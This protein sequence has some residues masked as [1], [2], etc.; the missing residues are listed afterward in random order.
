MTQTDSLKDPIYKQIKDSIFPVIAILLSIHFL[1]NFTQNSGLKYFYL[2]EVAYTIFACL[3]YDL[4]KAMIALMGL[5]FIEGQ[6]RIIWEYNPLMR[7]MFDLVCGLAVAKSLITY[8][9]LFS[10]KIPAFFLFCINLHFFWYVVQIFNVYNAGILPVI[11]ASKIYIFPFILFFV[12]LQNPIYLESREFKQIQ[13]LVIFLTLM[14]V[15]LTVYQMNGKEPVLLSISSYYHTASKMGIFTEKN[16]R[17]FGTSFL[18]GGMSMYLHVTVPLLLI[19]T[20]Q[21]FIKK[22]VTF[23]VILASWFA[24]FISQVRALAFKHVLTVLLCWIVLFLASRKSLFKTF[25]HNILKILLILPIFFLPATHKMLQELDLDTAIDRFTV[26]AEEGGSLEK[27]RVNLDQAIR[28]MSSKIKEAPLGV[29]PGR[30]GAAGSLGAEATRNDP[31]FNKEF[32]WTADNLFISLAI[33]FGVGMIFYLFAILGLVLWLFYQT[34]L[35]YVHG[36]YTL[37]SHMGVISASLIVMLI[38]NWGAISVPYNPESFMF[39]FLSAIA[40]NHYNREKNSRVVSGIEVRT[41]SH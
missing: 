8:K 6:G 4:P 5:F 22:F 15:I 34:I 28:I 18:P 17:P 7:I 38:G 20:S 36:N 16:F 33:D 41:T 31:I 21:T 30:T 29:G 27:H 9:Y 25:K 37:F 11:G 14:E 35:A 26:I 1:L 12:L 39:W 40:V 19:N 23:A 24:L 10:K 2:I 32:A 3:Y 13:S